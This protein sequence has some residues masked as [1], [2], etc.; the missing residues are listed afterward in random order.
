MIVR[1]YASEP[2]PKGKP[3]QGRRV[4]VQSAVTGIVTGFAIAMVRGWNSSEKDV[5]PQSYKEG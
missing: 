5:S 2:L 3:N 1:G 4:L